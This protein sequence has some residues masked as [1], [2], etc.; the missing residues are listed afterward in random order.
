MMPPEAP[1]HDASA[2]GTRRA[3][4]GV[5]VPVCVAVTGVVVV[6]AVLGGWLAPQD[7][8]HQN[9]LSPAAGPSSEHWLGTDDL[10]RDIFSRILTGTRSAVVG[11]IVAAI[12]V[13]VIG[14]LLGLLA[15]F[16][17]GRLEAVIM[18]IVDLVYAM[19]ALLVIIVLIGL[20]SGGYWAAVG[21][22]VL[23]ATPGTTRILRAAVLAQRG[24]PYVEAARTVGV[25]N[26]RLIFVH[27]APN[28]L[29]TVVTSFLLEFVGALVA[30]SALSFLG[31]GV[32]PGSADW[33]RMLAENRGLLELNPWAVL[34]PALMLMITATAVTV[35][36]DWLYERFEKARTSND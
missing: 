20:F 19:P 1:E 27:V 12:G 2:F 6:L 33:G 22:L 10:G 8:G 31:L 4:W 3:R 34:A 36:G 15:G 11:P 17:G 9:L 29:P 24:L 30:L 25:S 5:L 35:L 7:P 14:L 32:P 23:L 26:R 21:V 13:T 16:H 28:V 18:R